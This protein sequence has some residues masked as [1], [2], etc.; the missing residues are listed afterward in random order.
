MYYVLDRIEL[1]LLRFSRA[2]RYWRG[3]GCSWRK[4]W[5]KAGTMCGL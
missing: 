1:F 2:W 4:A 5:D 3:L